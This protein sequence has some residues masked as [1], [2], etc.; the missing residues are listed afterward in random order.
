MHEDVKWL[1]GLLLVFAAI[2]FASG[3]LG[4]LSNTRPFLDPTG[5]STGDTTNLDFAHIGTNSTDDIRYVSMPTVTE[6]GSTGAP[7]TTQ[8]A[9][10]KGLQDA[11]LK[12]DE[13]KKE[14]AALEAASNASPLKGKL[15]IVGRTTGG[16]APYEYI[17]IRAST[18][19]KEKVL[20]T[21]LR[22][23][24]VASGRGADIPK[25]VPLFFQNELNQE[26]PIYL[27][28]GDSA[29]IVT[30]RSSLGTSFRL[31]KCTGFLNQFQTIYPNI[32]NRCPQP[33]EN[34]LPVGGTIYNDA[35]RVYINALPSCRVILNPPTSLSPECVRYVTT[36]INYTKCLQYHK[37]DS[38]FYDPSWR[39][40]LNRT[41]PLWKTS[42]E[43]IHLV[44]GNDK[45]IDAITY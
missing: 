9:I 15:A 5:H 23:E 32:P 26:Q 7:L 3:S 22:L 44:D 17:L 30:G 16:G 13:I 14:L 40:Y 31:N 37:N 10:Q 35:C 28:P 33:S 4:R 8:E 24:S 43:V 39:I 21:G 42:R 34:D 6:S 2:F 38:D 11:G 27:A 25:G 29:Y 1:F 20:I 12:A 45:L 36:E 18:E 41:D 19:N